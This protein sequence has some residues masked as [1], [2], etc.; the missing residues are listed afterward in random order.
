VIAALQV[1]GFGSPI[2]KVDV[3][4]HQLD[5]KIQLRFGSEPGQIQIVEASTNFVNWEIIGVAHEQSDGAFEFEDPDVARFPN[6]FYRVS[7]P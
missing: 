6:R 4:K 2:T 7:T 1:G 3:V 5:G